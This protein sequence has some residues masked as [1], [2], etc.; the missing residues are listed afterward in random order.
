MANGFYISDSWSKREKQVAYITGFK[1]S[2]DTVTVFFDTETK[3]SL[4]DSIENF[5]DFLQGGEV[6]STEQVKMEVLG[7]RFEVAI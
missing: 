3:D 2:G 4:S 7:K 5:T 6:F 1:R